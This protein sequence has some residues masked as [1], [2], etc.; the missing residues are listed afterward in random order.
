MY[1]ILLMHDM[2]IGECQ[3]R[4]FLDLSG[5]DVIEE[6]LEKFVD[7]Y[8]DSEKM[9]RVV[10]GIIINCLDVR[11]WLAV[12]EKIRDVTLVPVMIVSEQ[13]DEWV[14]VH[15]FQCGVDD[16]LVEPI[17]PSELIAR[18]RARI[19]RYQRLTRPLGLIRIRDL[20]I[21]TVSRQVRLNGKEIDLTVKEF[22]LLLFLV[23]H[24]GKVVTKSEIYNAVWNEKQLSG[25]NN[26]VA[27]HIKKLRDK[28]ETD[29]DNPQYIETVWGVG[30]RFCQQ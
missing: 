14:K 29:I 9:L 23:Q 3:I 4:D 20:Q 22:D 8:M 27:V 16:Y 1:R 28:I 10:D 30:Y 26:C 6:T 25:Y 5:Y 15:M 18:I 7:E 21:Q 17:R 19:E 11:T 12:C 24:S 13:N 2:Q